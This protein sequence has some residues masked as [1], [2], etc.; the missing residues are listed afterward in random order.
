MADGTTDGTLQHQVDSLRQQVEAIEVNL[1]KSRQPWYRTPS[2]IISTMALLFSFGTTYVSYERTKQQDIHDARAELR[3]LIL[4]LSALPRENTE[5]FQKY[6][7]NPQALANLSSALNAENA[8][9]AKQ[10]AEVIERIPSHV[11]STEYYAVGY[12]LGNSGLLDRSLKVLSRAVATSSD[13]NDEIGALRQYA[14]TLF[15]AG[16]PEGGPEHYRKALA[17]FT[18][19]PSNNHSYIEST[20]ALTE[21]Y[22]AQMEILQRQCSYAGLHL[23]EAKKHI[24]ALP[25][26]AFAAQLTGQLADAQ[27]QVGGCRP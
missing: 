23:Q 27:K 13:V 4:R 11:S 24:E 2:V 25:P 10:A 6:G 16:N 5:L 20:H 7:N 9:I 22:W 1:L 18:K 14:A 19:Y 15:S 17:I 21:I 8:L 12:A 3:T 26:L